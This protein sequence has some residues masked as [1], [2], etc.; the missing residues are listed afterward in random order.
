MRKFSNN[1]NVDNSDLSNFPDA[2]IKNNTGAGD[3]TA[4]NERVYGDI[5]QF[6]LKL[7]RLAGIIE[8]DLPDN[9]TNGFQTI[10]SLISIAS[11]NDYVYNL[12]SVSDV[13]QVP[14]KIGLMKTG[15]FLI[16]KSAINLGIE[17]TIKGSDNVT[18]SAVSNSNFKVNDFLLIT[19]TASNFQI[20][21]LVDSVNLDL[22]ASEY[23]YLKKANQTEENA[24]LIDSKATTPLSNLTAFVRRVIGVDSVNYLATAIRNGLYPKEHFVIVAG[25]GASPIKNKGFI[26]G[27]DVGG[28]IG[29]LAVSGDMVSATASVPSAGDTFVTVNFANAMANT[30]YVVKMFI[31]SEGSLNVDNDIC[32]PVFKPINTTQFQLAIRETSSGAQS[33]KIHIEVVQL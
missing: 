9:E 18:I 8:N 20:I 33:L 28:T 13:L 6:F 15:E 29:S 14:V 30:N 10:D 16:C 31:Q 27:L 23:N 5:I 4:V 2:R 25:L 3:G 24:G 32:Y 26:S 11:K 17:T 19:K 1:P 21:R 7:K 22:V 12:N